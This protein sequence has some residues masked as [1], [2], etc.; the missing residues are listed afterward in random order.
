M[1]LSKRFWLWLAPIILT[2]ILGLSGPVAAQHL[3]LGRHGAPGA[4]DRQLYNPQTVTTVQ[5]QVADLG[6]YGMQGW[7]VTPGMALRGLVLKTPNGNLTVNLGPP[8][9]V[10]KQGFT[11]QTGDTLE[12]TGSKV[13]KDEKTVLLAAEVKK[14]GQTL[15]VRDEKGAPLFQGAGSRW[16]RYQRPGARR[17]GF[18]RPRPG[19]LVTSSEA[20]PDS[21]SAVPPSPVNLKIFWTPR[22]FI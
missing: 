9:Y 18:R 10:S 3:G 15:K 17:H 2:T 22:R 14:N 4:A 7:R 19:K 1:H 11:L 8:W 13:I 16:A 21:R 12:V 5:G 20:G 6:S